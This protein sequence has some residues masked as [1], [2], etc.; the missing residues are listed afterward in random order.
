MSYRPDLKPPEDPYSYRVAIK[1]LREIDKC[2]Q[3]PPWRNLRSSLEFGQ[4]KGPQV[5][6]RHLRQIPEQ[7][8]NVI[9]DAIQAARQ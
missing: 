2:E 4:G 7:D 6:R 8:F 9:A 1:T 3:M 5:L